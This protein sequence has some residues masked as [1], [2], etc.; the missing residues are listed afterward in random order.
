[1][2]KFGSGVTFPY[3]WHD[4]F[5]GSKMAHIQLPTHTLDPRPTFLKQKNYVSYFLLPYGILNYYR[6]DNGEVL[7]W[8]ELVAGNGGPE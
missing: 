2:V 3:H 5:F 7:F 8:V 4:S 1:M 6:W